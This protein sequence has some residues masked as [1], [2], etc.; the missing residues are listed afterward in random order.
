MTAAELDIIVGANVDE[1]IAAFKKLG[2]EI[3]KTE[4]VAGKTNEALKKGA[5]S[6]GLALTDLGR[7]AQDIPFGFAAIQNNLNPLLESFK[8]LKAETGGTGTAFK[9]LL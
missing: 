2:Y 5:N 8:R 4:Q 7:V 9:A 1:A 6:A 3:K